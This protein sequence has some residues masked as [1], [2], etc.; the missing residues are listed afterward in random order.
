MIKTDYKNF[1]IELFDDINDDLDL[2]I[3]S[4]KNEIDFGSKKEKLEYISRHYII[5]KEL[6]IEISNITIY[7]SNSASGIYEDTFA[8]TDNKLLVISGNEIYC[9]EIPS[10]KL[11]WHKEFDQAA[12]FALYKLEEDFIIYG[13]IG[14]FR[15]TK[16]GEIVWSFWGRDIWVNLKGKNP[17]SVENDKIRLFD[18]ESN[19]YILD[20]NGNLIEDNPILIPKRAQKKWWQRFG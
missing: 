12:N 16:E 10:L 5:V 1:E 8:V 7:E 6:G 2:I 4:K 11:I 14:I 13:E 17:F 18:F 9:L 3:K 19:E 15:I 20:F